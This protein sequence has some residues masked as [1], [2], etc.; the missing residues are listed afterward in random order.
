MRNTFVKT[1]VESA[2]KDDRINLIIGDLGFNVVTPFQEKFPKRFFNA[3]IAEQNMTGVAAGMAKEGKIVV[4]YSIANFTTLRCLEQIRNDCAYHDVN[5]KIV[6]VG[7]GLA[8]GAAGA[9]HHATED[10]AI[11]RSLPNVKVFAPGD[12]EE[13]KE[14]TQAMLKTNGTCYLR[15]GKGGEKKIHAENSIDFKIGKA[16]ELS[17]GKDIAIFSTGGILDEAT[18]TRIKLENSGYSVAQYSFPTVKPIDKETILKCAKNCKII[19]TIEEH[20]IFGGFGSAVAEVLSEKNNHAKLLRFGLP[21]T[22]A[23]VVGSQKYLR[24]YYGL[25]ADKIV[26]KIVNEK[27]E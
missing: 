26:E 22:Y 18:E 23:M 7:G 19:V 15:L 16:I 13:A 21:D 27:M 4:T 12:P 2:Q 3:G 9:T 6:S 20:N 1:L 14:V 25:T 10:I 24:N 5:V 11:M 8:Y 17:K